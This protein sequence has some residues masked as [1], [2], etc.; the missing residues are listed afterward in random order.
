M[1]VVTY[2]LLCGYTPFGASSLSLLSLTLNAN[3]HSLVDARPQTATTRSTRSRRS[4]TPT[5]RSSPR[6]T[7]S[8]SATRVRLVAPCFPLALDVHV[9]RK[10]SARWDDGD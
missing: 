2:F 6:S 7:G 10:A 1:G 4:A 9:E 8:A 5:L 3:A